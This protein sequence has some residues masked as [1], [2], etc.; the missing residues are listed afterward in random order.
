LDTSDVEA[1]KLFAFS[2]R[3]CEVMIA[4]IE[5]IN[6]VL[7]RIRRYSSLLNYLYHFR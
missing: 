7:S 4:D 2:R 5:E 1:M 3:N 6:R